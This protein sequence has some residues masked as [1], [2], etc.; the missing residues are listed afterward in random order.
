MAFWMQYQLGNMGCI[1]TDSAQPVLES[2]STCQIR[3]CINVIA[4]H[5]STA[6]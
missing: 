4:T 6:R 3:Q 1:V 2:R 5:I